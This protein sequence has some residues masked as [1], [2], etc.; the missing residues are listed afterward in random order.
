M[1]TR[2]KYKISI[3]RGDEYRSRVAC[4]YPQDIFFHHAYTKAGRCVGEI[5]AATID[6]HNSIN[7]GARDMTIPCKP[8][9]ELPLTPFA[10]L[11]SYPNNVITFCGKRGQG[12]TS[13]MVSFAKALEH[14]HVTTRNY[15][16]DACTFWKSCAPDM[17]FHHEFIVID[18]IDP[19]TLEK[20]DSILRIILSRLFN[21]FNECWN[22]L[23]G[24]LYCPNLEN[25]K[26]A[27]KEQLLKDFRDCYRALDTL[28]DERRTDQYYDD[29]SYL[30]DLGDSSFLKGKLA[31]LVK[32]LCE[33]C[34]KEASHQKFLVIQ[35]DDTDLN[36]QRVFEIL[37]DVRRYFV[38]PNVIMLMA[39]EPQQLAMIVEQHYIEEFQV[40]INHYRNLGNA[41]PITDRVNCHNAAERY[42]DKLIPGNHQIHLPTVENIIRNNQ[43]DISLEYLQNGKNLM[44]VPDKD[45]SYQELL[46]TEIYHK[47]RIILLKPNS[48]L[49]NFL[50]RSM[51]M[52]THLL[53]FLYNLEDIPADVSEDDLYFENPNPT[54]EKIEAARKICAE[55]LDQI[56]HYFRQIWCRLR[57]TTAEYM[58]M[59]K[60]FGTPR[61][62]LHQQVMQ[63]LN[64]ITNREFPVSSTDAKYTDVMDSLRKIRVDTNCEKFYSI[65]FAI[66]FHYTLLMHQMLVSNPS[67][68]N[69]AKIYN[70]V[71]AFPFTLPSAAND[72]LQFRIP[73]SKLPDT[74]PGPL[75]SFIQSCC[76]GV[77]NSGTIES[78]QHLQLTGK[79]DPLREYKFIEYN[80]ES[81]FA[82]ETL[83]IGESLVDDAP[84]SE[85]NT[86]THMGFRFLI[87]T[88]LQ[89]LLQK[90]CRK[91]TYTR[92][93]ATDIPDITHGQMAVDIIGEYSRLLRE[94]NCPIPLS[95]QP[96]SSKNTI[97]AAID[98][99]HTYKISQPQANRQ[100]KPTQNQ[101]SHPTKTRKGR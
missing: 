79:A 85:P 42:L 43:A 58:E 50:P 6:Y 22:Q 32:H 89:K 98:Q 92:E 5:V 72:N 29:L 90:C 81:L 37:E 67:S 26:I 86:S 69:R 17:G 91:L 18:P 66:E 16:S 80:I 19:T 55:N 94:K 9:D 61:S 68:N 99:L 44:D 95:I 36:A 2:N 24:S 49:H 83:I 101:R 11:A 33:F 4:I 46:L 21:K 76:T 82:A 78:L 56:E 93:M 38:I 57:L 63:S 7:S 53:S 3:R 100:R 34:G 71:G 15:D 65:C 48:Y 52:L 39:A 12:K 51:R 70:F 27:Q 25:T 1:P 87:N 23:A 62:I 97:M 73:T 40:M 84:V 88:D 77:T 47:T 60:I 59:E 10:K 41:A 75:S 13:A 96:S 14:F 31:N 28:K 45:L 30:A 35:I 74:L 20:T 8:E 64:S 54:S